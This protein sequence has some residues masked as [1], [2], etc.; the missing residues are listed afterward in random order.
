MKKMM[1]RA[2]RMII[3]PK[4]RNPKDRK[5]CWNSMIVAALLSCGPFRAIITDP[6]WPIEDIGG[7]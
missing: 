1:M 3:E 4:I 5:R 7:I 2:A 6:T